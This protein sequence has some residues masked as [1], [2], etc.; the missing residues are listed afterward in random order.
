MLCVLFLSS[1]NESEGRVGRAAVCE[2]G[3]EVWRVW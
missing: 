1:R 2:E 3:T